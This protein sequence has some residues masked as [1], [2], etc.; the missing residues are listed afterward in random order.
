MKRIGTL[1]AGWKTYQRGIVPAE[2]A[3]FPLRKCRK[4]NVP[5]PVSR[6]FFLPKLQKTIMNPGGL[7]YACR[8]CWDGS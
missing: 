3:G 6:V 1:T 5:F 7:T 4:C 8:D 2:F